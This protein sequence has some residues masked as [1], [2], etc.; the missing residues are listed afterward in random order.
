MA[1]TIAQVLAELN[2]EQQ[3]AVFNTKTK[4]TLLL[5]GP[6]SGKTRVLQSRYLSL[7]QDGYTTGQIMAVTFT[8]KAANELKERIGAYLQPDDV[9]KAW[10]GTFHSTCIRLMHIYGKQMGIDTFQIADM[11]DSKKIIK[12]ILEDNVIG[13]DK[14]TLF[15]M[16]TTI[17]DLKS[18]FESPAKFAMRAVSDLDRKISIVYTAYEAYLQSHNLFDFD[19]CIVRMVRALEAYPDVQQKINDKF[20]YLMIDECQDTDGAQ[21]KLIKMLGAGANIFMVGDTD[22]CWRGDGVVKTT[23]GEKSVKD[24]LIGDIVQTVRKQELHYSEVTNKSMHYSNTL[25]VTT[26]LGYV[27]NVT[28]NHKCFA[29]KPDFKSGYYYVYLMY[30]KDKGFRIGLMTGGLEGVAGSRTHSEKPDRF[31][32]IKQFT[33]KNEATLFEE[34][35]SLKYRIPKNVYFHNGR[36]INLNQDGLNEIYAE[37]GMNGMNLIDDYEMK[38][39]YPNHIPKGM[40]MGNQNRAVINLIMNSKK[41]GN[42]VSYEKDDCRIRKCFITYK[43]AFEYA[44]NLL[45]EKNAEII[46]EKFMFPGEDNLTVI[47]AS[48]LTIGMSIPIV[49]NDVCVLDKIVS[50]TC[51]TI[52]NQV[53]DIEVADTGVLV[54]DNIVTHNSLYGWRGARPDYFVRFL[55]HYPKGQILELSQNYRST[56]HIINAGNAII[57]NNQLRYAKQ[58]STNKSDGHKVSVFEFQNNYAEAETVVRNLWVLHNSFNYEWKDMV[59]LYRI[60]AHSRAFE[61]ELLKQ[62]IPYKIIGGT[63]FY[64]RKEIRDVIAYL[65]IIVNPKHDL[66]FR[67]VLE[68]QPGV[69]KTSMS[70][71]SKAAKAQQIS[72]CEYI[73]NMKV[74]TPRL[75]EFFSLYNDVCIRTSIGT[76]NIRDMINLVI[77]QFAYMDVI[78]KDPKADE[79]LENLDELRN[80]ALDFQEKNPTAGLTEFIEGFTLSS[81]QDEITGDNTVKLMTGHAA[82]GLEFPVVFMVCCEEGILPHARCINDLKQLE[83]ERRI[84]FVMVTRGEERVLITYSKQRRDRDGTIT[85]QKPSRFIAEIPYSCKDFRVM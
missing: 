11:D 40:A 45:I 64:D 39:D 34:R 65:K 31:W 38:F 79:R 61:D 72:L 73:S 47:P 14:K 46:A 19:D 70:Q 18:S 12:E 17:S 36:G 20:K 81:D 54:V 62:K 32:I 29:T 74:K 77:K 71:V 85:T 63:G 7:I 26:S 53:F 42:E 44:Q 52:S 4:D 58:M 60:N 16:T 80:L 1:K 30:R 41:H 50:I 35:M 37:F 23:T 84:A 6:G 75:I 55:E 66:A 49:H 3:A 59:I 68:L 33:D 69:G 78:A 13:V 21:H 83:E 51:S 48:Q 9:A 27:I 22:Q 25:A 82:K 24:I 10:I 8:N 76:M 43:I 15:D 2:K 5:A 28:K 57:K 67:R 56:G